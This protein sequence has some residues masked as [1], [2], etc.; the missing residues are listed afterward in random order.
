[1][2]RI[3][4]IP[5]GTVLRGKCRGRCAKRLDNYRDVRHFHYASC[6]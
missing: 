5:G 6:A 1:M 2:R 3:A 4:H